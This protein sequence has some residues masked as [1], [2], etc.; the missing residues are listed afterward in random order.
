MGSSRGIVV[1]ADIADPQAARAMVD[2]A[3]ALPRYWTGRDLWT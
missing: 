2:S 1:Q 3:A